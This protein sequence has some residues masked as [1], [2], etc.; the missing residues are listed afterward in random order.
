MSFLDR[1]RTHEATVPSRSVW[2]FARP[3]SG[4]SIFPGPATATSSQGKFHLCHWGILV[5][6]LSI[7]DVKALTLRSKQGSGTTDNTPLGTLWELIRTLENQSTVNM[8]QPF[9]VS[10]LKEQWITFSAKH[11]GSTKLT[12]EQ[13]QNEGI[14]LAKH[15]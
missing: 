11:I 8:S 7:V 15:G 6:D 4:A 2:I 5:T 9:R 12:D 1:F 10:M 13:V 3:L 14:N